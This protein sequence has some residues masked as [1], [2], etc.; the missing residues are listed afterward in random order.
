MKTRTMFALLLCAAPLA[1][2]QTTTVDIPVV[3]IPYNTAHGLR[4]PSIPQSL[5]LGET[6]YEATHRGIQRALDDHKWLARLAIVGAD[7]VDTVILPLPG[8]DGWVH[9][10]YHR[11]VLGQRGFG[12]RNDVYLFKANTDA[13]AVS[14]VADEDLVRLKQDHPAEQVRLSAAGLEAEHQLIQGLEKREFFDR[15]R[16]FQMP[17]Y[18]LEKISSI[19]YVMSGTWDETNGTTDDMNREDGTNVAKRDF[20]G[21]DFT[22]WIYDLSRPHEPYQARGVHPAGVG[23]DRYIKPSDLTPEE[24]AYLRHQGRLQLLNLLDPFLVARHHFTVNVHGAPLR[25][26]ANVGH[27]LTSFGRTIDTNLFVARGKANVLLTVHAYAN[28]ERSFAGL[29]AALVDR[30]VTVF[31]RALTVSP[32]IAI[33]QQPKGQWFRTSES[34]AGGLV[35]VK[36]RRA[37]KGRL[38]AFAELEVKTAGWS[39]GSVALDRNASARVGVS[40]RMQ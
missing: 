33:W 35:A 17:I 30:P 40:L 22:A 26:N 24:F 5:A 18:W 13:I 9:E 3:D 31:G 21:H 28:G 2:A 38:G 16:S 23:I 37:G 6:F 27:L 11:A 36:V 39:A 34:S 1:N 15:S 25:L 7:L 29:E 10:E 12:S 14:H 20:T 19:A 8:S 32:R 4:A